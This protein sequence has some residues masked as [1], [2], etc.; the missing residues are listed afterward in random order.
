MR[1]AAF[2]LLISATF[3][4]SSCT[5]T[6]ANVARGGQLT[7]IEV[8]REIGFVN[9]TFKLDKISVQTNDDGT[10]VFVI[11]FGGTYGGE[12]IDAALALSSEWDEERSP[13]LPIPT[14]WSEISIGAVNEQSHALVRVLASAYGAQ[15][16]PNS[17]LQETVNAK[18]VSIG[19]KPIEISSQPTHLK[20]FFAKPLHDEYGEVYLN[21]DPVKKIVEWNEKDPE[22]RGAILKALT[23]AP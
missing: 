23:K 3:L 21:I 6:K 13:G 1:C 20:I 11:Y 16:A 9:I 8:T 18:I 17:Q 5:S 14:Y 19:V 22:Y 4:V 2:A 12:S 15:I 7:S 10:K